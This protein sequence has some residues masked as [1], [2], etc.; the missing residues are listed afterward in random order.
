MYFE[1]VAETFAKIGAVSSR[2]EITKLLAE[3]LKNASAQE[4]Q[5]LCNLSLG[6]LRPSYE[7][8][9][10]FN[11]AEKS[12]IKIV[13]SLTNLSP[14]EVEAKAKELGDVGLVIDVAPH[15]HVVKQI[16]LMEVF[17]HLVSLER[18]SGTG[19]QEEKYE[20]ALGLL[21]K[22]DPLSAKYVVRIILG[23]LRLGFSDMTLIDA[24]S[25][26]EVGDKSLHT[27]L[28][29]AYNVCADIGLI[30][31][32]LKEGGIEAIKDMHSKLGIPI[33]MAAAE[34]L[35]DAPT[36]YEKLGHCAAQPK[37]D[38]FRLQIHIDK[39]D[40]RHP[41]IK[42]FSR[43][44]LD[45]SD[46][47]PDL[48]EELLKLD[49]KDLICEGEAIGYDPDTGLFIP[50]QE[51]VKRKRKHGIEQARSEYPLQLFLFDILYHNGKDVMEKP[52]FERRKELEGVVEHY[53]GNVIKIISEI[54]IYS[55][56]QLEEYF[57]TTIDAGLE[58][59]MVKKINSPY[60]PGKRNFNW[61][62]LKRILNSQLEDT[63]DCVVLGY[64]RGSG[65]RASL[66]IGAFLVGIYNKNND[67]F[68]TLAKIGTG[69]KD[70]E[71][72]ELE[73]K[74]DALKIADKPHNVECAKELYPDIWVEPKIMCIVRADEITISPLHTAG[75]TE[76]NL[77]FALRFPR[78][79]AYSID[80]S[81]E[82]S[83]SPE[84][85]KKLY[86]DQAMKSQ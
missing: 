49:V 72:R 41:I 13:S 12:L 27:A 17:E 70:D 22:L 1:R 75:K 58:G 59:I 7:G 55:W 8:S 28:E 33:R 81:P 71:W 63:I 62:K 83:T 73:K 15:E 82:Q 48:T 85:I 43:N 20:Y 36:I 40:V 76:K 39:T 52:H 23:K 46:T 16:S 54:S 45:M 53:K 11:L 37:L 84:E 77:G 67:G 14:Q 19:S 50:F 5:V 64:Y 60:Q 29:N 6:M 4:A 42:L 56:Q 47:F 61:I 86:E 3:L 68:Q 25:W 44:L 69:L 18:I 80:K 35:S 10:Q 26:M 21:Q 24:L 78:F 38:G 79:V 31:L 34:R 32:T 74:C 65:K 30:A 66:G 9:T 51:T 2:T 57:L